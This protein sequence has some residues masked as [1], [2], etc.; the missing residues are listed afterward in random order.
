MKHYMEKSNVF[1]CKNCVN[2]KIKNNLISCKLKYFEN[3]TYK[4]LDLLT[5][6][7]FECIYFEEI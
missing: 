5:P 1:F 6:F 4:E 2:C 7:D 3:I